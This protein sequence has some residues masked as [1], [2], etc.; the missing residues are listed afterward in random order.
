MQMDLS[1]QGSTI[2]VLYMAKVDFMVKTNPSTLGITS[3]EK[4]KARGLFSFQMAESILGNGK[5]IR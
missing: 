2:M 1:Y 5:T 4:W 3:S